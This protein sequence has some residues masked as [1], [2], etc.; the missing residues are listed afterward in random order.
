MDCEFK[1][2]GKGKDGKTRYKCKRCKQP[3]YEST[4]PPERIHRMC[5]AGGVTPPPKPLHEDLPEESRRLLFG[6]RIKQL[7]D[8][9]GIPQC[10]GCAARQEWLNNAHKWVLG[11]WG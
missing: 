4:R 8:A 7:T 2:L 11:M 9:I 5:Q 6:D 1:P 3:V 10:G